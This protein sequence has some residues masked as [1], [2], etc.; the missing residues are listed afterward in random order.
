MDFD[1][2]TFYGNTLQFAAILG[3]AAIV[4]FRLLVRDASALH[5]ALRVLVSLLIVTTGVSVFF[6]AIVSLNALSGM[7][8]EAGYVGAVRISLALATGLVLGSP[9]AVLVVSALRRVSPA[10][11]S[12]GAPVDAPTTT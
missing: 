4:E 2:Q 10:V 12:S 3:L 1:P 9:F 7:P 11:R 6:A 8:T 5:L